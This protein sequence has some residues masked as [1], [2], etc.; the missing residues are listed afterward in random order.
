MVA[1]TSRKKAAELHGWGW[2][3]KAMDMSEI[4]NDKTAAIAL[5]E[6]GVIFWQPIDARGEHKDTWFRV[7]P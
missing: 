6:P 3:P 2:S 7:K 4:A 5:A 1:T